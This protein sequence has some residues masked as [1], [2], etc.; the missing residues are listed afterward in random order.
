MV[1]EIAYKLFLVIVGQNIDIKLDYLIFLM[2]LSTGTF[3][4]GDHYHK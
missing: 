1:E 2:E 3:V 4:L